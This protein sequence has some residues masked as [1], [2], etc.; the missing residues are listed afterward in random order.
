MQPAEPLT[1]YDVMVTHGLTQKLPNLEVYNLNL[2][3]WFTFQCQYTQYWNWNV[4]LLPLVAHK[5]L[6]DYRQWMDF[7]RATTP[8]GGVMEEPP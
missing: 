5:V 3:T 4:S 8:C 7:L 1:F 2:A 6:M